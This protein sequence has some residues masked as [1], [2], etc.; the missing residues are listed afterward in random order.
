MSYGLA[1]G[2]DSGAVLLPNW[3]NDFNIGGNTGWSVVNGYDGGGNAAIVAPLG[4][5][6]RIEYDLTIGVIAGASSTGLSIN[7]AIVNNGSGI[8]YNNTWSAGYY[9][10]CGSARATLNWPLSGSTYAT[11]APGSCAF[12]IYMGK[13]AQYPV[14]RSY[15]GYGRFNF[16]I[17]N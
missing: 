1:A 5:L 15:T 10:D 17:L 9:Q 6:L 2:V 7:T 11:T 14:W 4:C 13:T 3:A 12:A 16:T 8:A